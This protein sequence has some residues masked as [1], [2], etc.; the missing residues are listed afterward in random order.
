MTA[1]PVSPRHD[2]NMSEVKLSGQA[3]EDWLNVVLRKIVEEDD[4]PGKFSKGG[5]NQPPT[6]VLGIDM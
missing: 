1:Q 6:H 4:V 2:E 3:I 5:P